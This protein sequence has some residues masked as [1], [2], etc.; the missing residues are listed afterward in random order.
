MGSPCLFSLCTPVILSVF[1]ELRKKCSK[2][3]Q[4]G[5]TFLYENS[6]EY[7]WN[8]DPFFLFPRL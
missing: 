3:K 1:A 6:Y 5:R 4:R 8:V 2:V 7:F